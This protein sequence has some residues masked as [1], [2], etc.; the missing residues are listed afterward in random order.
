MAMSE[1]EEMVDLGCSRVWWREK[2]ERLVAWVAARRWGGVGE[3]ERELMEEI[4][5]WGVGWDLKD[6]QYL[7]SGV[8]F[9]EVWEVGLRFGLT[10]K[11]S[12]IL[13]LFSAIDGASQVEIFVILR[14]SARFFCCLLGFRVLEGRRL[15]CSAISSFP[16]LLRVFFLAHLIKPF[17]VHKLGLDPSN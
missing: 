3:K 11:V 14:R 4:R 15:C 7:D 2:R 5:V 6:F 12:D 1:K 8:D 10:A 13:G 17:S 16:P 9:V